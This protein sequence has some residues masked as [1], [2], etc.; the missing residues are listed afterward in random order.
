MFTCDE[1]IAVDASALFNMLTGYAQG[2]SWRKLCIAPEHLHE[3][4]IRLIGEQAD[5]ARRGKASRIIVK[6]NALVDH[7]VIEAL[8]RASQ[9]GVPIDL[10]VRGICCLRPGVKGLSE[11]IRVRSIVDRFLEHSRIMVF[12]ADES[13]KVYL[14]SAD[15]MPRNFF[16]R[17]EVMVPIESAPLKKR[18]LRDILPAYLRD[19]VRARELRGDGS[20]VTITPKKGEA[21]Y[22]CQHGLA[23]LPMFPPQTSTPNTSSGKQSKRRSRKKGRTS[24]K[25]RSRSK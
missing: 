2:H 10:I 11:N 13:A 19:N 1:D 21:P 15:W 22:R 7:K 16:R 8:Y 24:K 23:D 5:C 25:K 20:Y 17:V 6:L 3:R 18:I 14:S 9:A 12:G 4:T